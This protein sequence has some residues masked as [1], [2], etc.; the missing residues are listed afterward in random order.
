MKFNASDFYFAIQSAKP[1]KNI[2]EQIQTYIKELQTQKTEI[3]KEG[4]TE[5]IE[6][7]RSLFA[8][9]IRE[10]E[11]YSCVNLLIPLIKEDDRMIV[12]KGAIT[13]RRDDATAALLESFPKEFYN[14]NFSF[15]NDYVSMIMEAGMSQSAIWMVEKISEQLQYN[16]NYIIISI[17]SIDNNKIFSIL[18]DNKIIN[19]SNIKI[20]NLN[21]EKIIFLLENYPDIYK[22]ISGNKIEV[23]ILDKKIKLDLLGYFIYRDY[24][25]LAARLLKDGSFIDKELLTFEGPSSEFTIL[26]SNLVRSPEMAEC[27]ITKGFDAKKFNKPSVV[28]NIMLNYSSEIE[29]FYSQEIKEAQNSRDFRKDAFER[30]AEKK[31]VKAIKSSMLRFIDR[32]ISIS[33][34]P[35]LFDRPS[36]LGD[37]LILSCLNDT[38]NVMKFILGNLF[39]RMSS[40]EMIKCFKVLLNDQNYSILSEIIK[41]YCSVIHGEVV[42]YLAKQCLSGLDTA[43]LSDLLE[44]EVFKGIIFN[45]GELLDLA[46]NTC[47]PEVAALFIQSGLKYSPEKVHQLYLTAT[48]QN[49][50]K[51]LAILKKSINSLNSKNQTVW[52]Y[53]S[54]KEI[55]SCEVKDAEWLKKE[56]NDGITQRDYQS[57]SYMM[58]GVITSHMLTGSFN[59]LSNYGDEDGKIGLEAIGRYRRWIAEVSH[60][61]K[62]K[63]FGQLRVQKNTDGARLMTPLHGRYLKYYRKFLNENFPQHHGNQNLLF[64]PIAVN[65]ASRSYYGRSVGPKNF[66]CNIH[67]EI[68]GYINEEKLNLTSYS[69]NG[70]G[71]LVWV[72]TSVNQLNKVIN[73]I[74]NLIDDVLK[75]EINPSHVGDKDK[76]IAFIGKIHW[77]LAHACF[78]NRG[79]AA[80]SEWIVKALFQ[81]H[82]LIIDWKTMPDCEAL[83]SPNVDDF[84][85]RYGELSTIEM[86]T[87]KSEEQPQIN[88][89]KFGESSI[90]SEPLPSANGDGGDTEGDFQKQLQCG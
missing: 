60:T 33:D 5:K 36:D 29:K 22:K 20:T 1:I 76:L 73:H 3:S 68:Y 77:W 40:Y 15:Y 69:N 45:D 35:G 24:V 21:E 83:I 2:Q 14:D 34:Y 56:F 32:F 30:I 17:S 62:Y 88:L 7:I 70:K 6:P 41:K 74:Q 13:Y 18:I 71:N 64:K 52:C 58:V 75:L 23:S 55:N 19:F 89:P 48:I 31:A 86:L 67:G 78:Y 79:S 27:L 12:L 47:L 87:L 54:K 43:V 8:V 9:L 11:L 65:Y 84:A 46:R 66:Y 16:K 10:D 61:K 50:F 38:N 26:L 85:A 57:Y 51:S 59:L 49:D 25:A 53:E 4:G 81:Y 42:T 82:G 63:L 39:N 90:F 80:I 37:L 28:F 44:N 72:H